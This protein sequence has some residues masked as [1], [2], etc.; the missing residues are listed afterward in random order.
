MEDPLL[1]IVIANDLLIYYELQVLF[2]GEV[3]RA[4]TGALDVGLG[5]C[6]ISVSHHV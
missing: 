1:R 4:L 6:L 2:D 3:A 5:R